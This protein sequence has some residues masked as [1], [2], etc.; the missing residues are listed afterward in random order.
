MFFGTGYALPELPLFL[1]DV[2]FYTTPDDNSKAEEGYFIG[3][4]MDYKLKINNKKH[5][6]Q[7]ITS[8]RVLKSFELHRNKSIRQANEELI[9]VPQLF[10]QKITA[11]KKDIK[12]PSNV[13]AAKNDPLW[14]P[15][16]EKEMAGFIKLNVF[17]KIN[18]RKKL[19]KHSLKMH[20]FWLFSLKP[21]LMT[22]KSRL[23]T[24][25]RDWVG[26]KNK[27]ASSPVAR[28]E[29]CFLMFSQYAIDKTT[30]ITTY[31]ISTAF[32][33]A[34]IDPKHY[35]FLDRPQGFED[36]FTTK[37]VKLEKHAYGLNTSPKAFHDKLVSVLHSIVR[38]VITDEC[39]HRSIDYK[40]FIVE[41]VDDIML[42]SHCAKK[43][44]K[45]LLDNFAL[46]I[47]RDPEYY[48]GYDIAKVNNMLILSMHTYIEK[49]I[50]D[51]PEEM[52]TFIKLPTRKTGN[53][54]LIDGE[55]P[56]AEKNILKNLYEIGNRRDDENVN[57]EMEYPKLDIDDIDIESLISPNEKSVKLK[58]ELMK[59]LKEIKGIKN[60]KEKYKKLEQL[61]LEKHN[62]TN[63]E[64]FYE[65]HPHFPHE[66]FSLRMYQKLVGI[67]IY[68][69]QK[70]RFDIQVHANMLA[71]YSSFPT[72]MQ[73]Y[74]ALQVL[75]YVYT[76][77]TS[78]YRYIREDK[79]LI[80]N[81]DGRI[82]DPIKLDVYTDASHL[83]HTSQ[84][85]YYIV[86]NQ[87]YIKS[88]SYRI[89]Q[90]A[91]CSFQAEILAVRE[92]VEAAC[93]IKTT[94]DDF[95]YNNIIV[96]IYCDNLPVVETIKEQH[97]R[98]DFKEKLLLN[99]YHKLRNY[100]K[101]GLF[102]IEHIPGAINPADMLTKT[103]GF[104][105]LHELLEHPSI[106]NTFCL[107]YTE[108]E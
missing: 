1:E 26:K 8:Y 102:D 83:P 24:I 12:I 69:S 21:P 34:E 39:L 66:L 99:T 13:Y 107:E 65:Q 35:Y 50:N 51:L 60:D 46:K 76:T 20:T 23:I 17:S 14:K 95:G 81:T 19:P 108:S 49:A 84:G 45:L 78:S 105:K 80:R 30:D 73:F 2:V 87:R 52:I 90:H 44:E 18:E 7:L 74:Q 57:M 91:D 41:H 72:I 25:H 11:I 70:G 9:F 5:K 3:Y 86:L 37:L 82:D 68:I 28:Q 106:N 48:L 32:L 56:Q 94:L 96:T 36:Y 98:P 38:D 93:D 31:D 42:L 43:L 63:Y 92:A 97:R 58:L 75:K 59:K 64:S 6:T 54:D 55:I 79:E 22:P 16:V 100:Y 104:T 67:L 89:V 61:V 29:S 33:H 10:Y 103:V 40:T 4:D 27:E 62:S 53:I 77:R 15:S 47:T 71:Q 101:M 85:G 88:K